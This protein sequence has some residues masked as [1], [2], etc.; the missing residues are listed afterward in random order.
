MNNILT[1]ETEIAAPKFSNYGKKQPK[2]SRRTSIANN[3]LD[4]LNDPNVEKYLKETQEKINRASIDMTTNNSG[5]SSENEDQSQH[6]I[7]GS[8]R[9]SFKKPKSN[10]S[11]SSSH[12]PEGST[13]SSQKAHSISGIP[14]HSKKG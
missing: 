10:V 5:I 3:I 14:S 1:C 12:H 6:A 2:H 7:I 13:N 11:G 9:N 4:S 8:R